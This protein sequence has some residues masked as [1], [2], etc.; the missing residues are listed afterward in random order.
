M[1]ARDGVVSDGFAPVAALT[2]GRKTSYVAQPKKEHWLQEE[3]H[4]KSKSPEVYV[5]PCEAEGEGEDRPIARSVVCGR[6][7]M[8]GRNTDRTL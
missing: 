6:E 3:K 1:H 8:V 2:A 4:R 7:A 5:R